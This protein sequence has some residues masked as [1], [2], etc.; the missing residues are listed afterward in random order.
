MEKLENNWYLEYRQYHQDI[1]VNDS[2]ISFLI[3]GAEKKVISHL[4]NFDPDIELPTV[5]PKITKEEA[6]EIAKKN[7]SASLDNDGDSNF[8]LKNSELVVYKNENENSAEYYLT[9]KLNIFSLQPLCDYSYF[10]NAENGEVVFS[11]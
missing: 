4:S 2:N 1:L 5:E 6:S 7:L 3:G 9:W 10:I 8:D 11:F